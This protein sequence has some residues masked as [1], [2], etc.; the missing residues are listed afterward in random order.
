MEKAKW[1]RLWPTNQFAAR[2]F[3]LVQF[4]TTKMPRSYCSVRLDGVLFLAGE[5]HILFAPQNNSIITNL[6]FDGLTV[7]AHSSLM[8]SIFGP[9]SIAPKPNAQTTAINN[10]WFQNSIQTISI[11]PVR[12]VLE[13]HVLHVHSAWIQGAWITR[14]KYESAKWK[15]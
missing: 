4:E 12:A 10:I 2:I 15:K 3:L 7:L 8:P 6:Y 14:R 11:S 5:P 9:F 1:L 13:V